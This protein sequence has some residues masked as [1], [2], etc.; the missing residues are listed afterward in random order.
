MMIKMM[1][2][3]VMMMMMMTMIMMMMMMNMMI[4]IKIRWEKQWLDFCE[5]PT[6]TRHTLDK[7]IS[8]MI[9]MLTMRK[10]M[11][12]MMIKIRWRY[13]DDEN[14]TVCQMGLEH[15]LWCVDTQPES[16]QHSH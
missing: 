10:M 6:T 4:P 11:M 2:M 9:M 3:T 16:V 13:E 7:Q 15:E 12:M 1:M 5:L 14:N 8:T